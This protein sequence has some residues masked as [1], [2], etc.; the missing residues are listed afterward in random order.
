MTQ[1]Y[2]INSRTKVRYFDI[3]CTFRRC[4]HPLDILKRIVSMLDKEETLLITLKTLAT[5][6]RHGGKES[7]NDVAEAATPGLIKALKT[8][9]NPQVTHLTTTIL[10]HTVAYIFFD[11]DPIYKNFPSIKMQEI[12][13]VVHK[14]LCDDGP[15]PQTF[16]HAKFLVMS[17]SRHAYFELERHPPSFDFIVG[18]L[19]VSDLLT[20]ATA[21]NNVLRTHLHQ[22]NPIPMMK[23]D[24]M[25]HLSTVQHLPRHLQDAVTQY[26]SEKSDLYTSLKA[27]RDYQV[28]QMK[29]AQTRN[30]FQLGL[31]LA[32]LILDS[33]YAI[34]EGVF[35]DDN[36]VTRDLGMPY[37]NFVDSLPVAA[38]ALRDKD[39]V[40]YADQADMLQMKFHIAR[41]QS[42][43]ARSVAEAAIARNNQN[44]Y[45]HYV[46]AVSE[47]EK[48]A[49]Q[50]RWA[51]RGLACLQIQKTRSPYLRFNLLDNAATA[52]L[53]TGLELLE[54]ATAKGSDS[55]ILALAF[56]HSAKNDATTFVNEAPPDCR[57]MSNMLVILMCT[58]LILR[59]N[60][61]SPDLREFKVGKPYGAFPICWIKPDEINRACERN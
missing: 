31:E 22:N 44:P 20:R 9:K 3:I 55:S 42:K 24:F 45:W 6:T 2:G 33:E 26:G 25:G 28:V 35:Q 8:H 59:G 7:R 41:K 23:P 19:R 47:G 46:C 29:A 27:V 36:G 43:S 5:I 49:R 39:P 54:T 50:L 53:E 30:Y 58:D 38:Q 40:K 12:L 4:L 51:K 21:M 11:R 48:T 16:D 60:E 13:P 52:A 56:L 10:A 15:A 17:A 1:L 34:S 18:C 37:N 14:A 61:M 32:D 57:G